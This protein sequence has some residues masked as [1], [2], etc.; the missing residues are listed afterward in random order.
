MFFKSTRQVCK[1][2][3]QNAFCLLTIDFYIFEPKNCEV[4]ENSSKT[5]LCLVNYNAHTWVKIISIS[6]GLSQKK[7]I[8]KWLPRTLVQCIHTIVEFK[9]L[10]FAVSDK[11][12]D[13]WKIRAAF[14]KYLFL[15]WKGFGSSCNSKAAL[16]I[17]QCVPNRHQ[18]NVW[19]YFFQMIKQEH[20]IILDHSTEFLSFL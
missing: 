19:C 12:G 9:V 14:Y 6:L 2:G 10:C 8:D 13:D 1:N 20:K 5:L 18:P 4:I 7:E 16:F 15:D 11:D 17:N 3:T